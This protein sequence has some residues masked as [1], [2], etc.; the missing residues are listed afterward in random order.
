MPGPA[1]EAEVE[2]RRLR[3]SAPTSTEESP[4]SASN[5]RSATAPLWDES[6]RY[7][8]RLDEIENDIEKRGAGAAPLC[9]KLVDEVVRDR[10]ALARLKIPEHACELIRESWRGAT[11]RSTAASISLM[12]GAP[13]KLLEYNADTPTALYEAAVVQWR[14]LEQI[15]AAAPARRRRPVQLRA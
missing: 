2:A 15:I 6:V 8:F 10:R 4:R 1:M 9:L 3:P 13:P 14:W 11:P 7:V 12:T 5:R